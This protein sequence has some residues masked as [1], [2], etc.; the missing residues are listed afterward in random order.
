[1][2]CDTLTIKNFYYTDNVLKIHYALTH[3][4]M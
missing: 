2:V 1:M 4:F 3:Q